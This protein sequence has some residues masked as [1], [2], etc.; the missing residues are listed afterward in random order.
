MPSRKCGL[1][2]ARQI[3]KSGL[4]L[5]LKRGRNAFPQEK[6]AAI[7]KIFGRCERGKRKIIK[8]E[9]YPDRP[10]PSVAIPLKLSGTYWMEY[11]RGK[12]IQYRRSHWA[13]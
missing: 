8:A 5:P 9:A 2:A 11:L 6:K 13:R 4:Q 10:H 7:G 3:A 12:A 1:P